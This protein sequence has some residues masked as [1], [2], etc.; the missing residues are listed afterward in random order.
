MQFPHWGEEGLED[1]VR[2]ERRNARAIRGVQVL[3]CGGGGGGGGCNNNNN[4]LKLRYEVRCRG[5]NA[6][7]GSGCRFVLQSRD[8]Y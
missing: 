6:T 2:Q 8:S 7:N 1:I 3:F 5:S 4:F